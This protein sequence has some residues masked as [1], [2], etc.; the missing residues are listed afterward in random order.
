MGKGIDITG[1]IDGVSKVLAGVQAAAPVVQKLG[2]PNVA[3]IATIGIAAIGVVQNVLERGRD[4]GAAMTEQDE[5][6]LKAMLAELQAANDTLA[7]AV[8]NS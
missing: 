1:L 7:N 4:L 6:K 2:G 3:N 8:N 5:A